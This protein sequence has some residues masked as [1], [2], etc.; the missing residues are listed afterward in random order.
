M[1][2]NSMSYEPWK[3]H[4]TTSNENVSNITNCDKEGKTLLIIWYITN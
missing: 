2:S 1:K 3:V 4:S